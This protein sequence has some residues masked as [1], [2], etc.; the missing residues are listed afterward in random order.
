[1]ES[2]ATPPPPARV[3]GDAGLPET[4]PC[5]QAACDDPLGAANPVPDYPRLRTMSGARQMPS[6]RT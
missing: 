1:M 3:C 2:R 6:E 5:A 4:C